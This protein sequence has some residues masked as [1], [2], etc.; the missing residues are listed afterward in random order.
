MELYVEPPGD[1]RDWWKEN[2]RMIDRDAELVDFKYAID[3][4]CAFLDN[5]EFF[6]I[7]VLWSAAEF[8]RVLGGRPDAWLGLVRKEI[9][10]GVVPGGEKMKELK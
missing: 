2:A 7:A 8:K 4:P 9:L 10:R 5:G 3:L 6:A 1:K